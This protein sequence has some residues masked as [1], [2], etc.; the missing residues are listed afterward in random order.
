MQA[1]H[2]L[3]IARS[4]VSSAETL[5]L[6]NLYDQLPSDKDSAVLFKID[7]TELKPSLS[8]LLDLT[9]SDGD[10]DILP[11]LRVFN[12]GSLLFI[13]QGPR[14]AMINMLNR[15]SNMKLARQTSVFSLSSE[16]LAPLVAPKQLVQTDEEFEAA[17]KTQRSIAVFVQNKVA[18]LIRREIMEEFSDVFDREKINASRVARTPVSY[19]SW[20][21]RR[22]N[23]LSGRVVVF[24]GEWALVSNEA[25]GRLQNLAQEN[26]ERMS[27]EVRSL[28][29]R[30]L[31]Q[32][33]REDAPAPEIAVEQEDALTNPIRTII[34]A[35]LSD[36]RARTPISQPDG[37]GRAFL[38]LAKL[39]PNQ[40]SADIYR[41][42][43]TEIK[44]KTWDFQGIRNANPTATKRYIQ[45]WRAFLTA[46][47]NPSAELPLT[48][49]NTKDAIKHLP[50]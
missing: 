24:A 1:C 39:I 4:E 7:F 36:H 49:R 29:N 30:I 35:Y 25:F 17:A 34:N 43:I 23:D 37:L 15:I 19:I 46:T 38:A 32:I 41:S 26:R 31:S 3:M 50:E 18:F 9:E 45:A 22:L 14:E 27:A 10:L 16:T 6:K 5:S 2:D 42:I 21:N 12:Q 47:K 40:R 20:I 44:F 13:A 11:D 33:G 8:L 28:N 48:L